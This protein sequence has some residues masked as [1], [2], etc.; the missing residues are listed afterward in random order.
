MVGDGGEGLGLGEL[1][2]GPGLRECGQLW[3]PLL[4][5]CRKKVRTY[6]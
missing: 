3:T 5:Q 4:D 6:S 2:D 1:F